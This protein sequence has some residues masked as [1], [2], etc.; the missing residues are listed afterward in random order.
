MRHIPINDLEVPDGWR[1]DAAAAIAAVEAHAGS[2]RKVRNAEIE[3]HAA[4]TWRAMKDA[5]M[6][7]SDDKCWYCEIRQDRSL[8]AV[9]HYRPKGKVD[10]VPTHP[11]YWW[12]A[13]DE[14]NY[15]FTC[16]LCNSATADKKS[17]IVGGKRDQFPLFDESKRATTP[18]SRRDD[19]SPKLLDPIVPLDPTLLTWMVDG[20]PAPRYSVSQNPEW[21]E[22]AAVTIAAYHLNHYR[23]RRRRIRIYNELKMLIQ[24][25]DILYDKAVTNQPFERTSME[26]VTGRIMSI[27]SERAELTATAKQYI[28]E[29]RTGQPNREWLEGVITAA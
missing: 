12:L 23:L 5:L 17:G 14:M 22:R 6:K 16:T 18:T 21:H 19:E 20:N 8:G 25:G 10:G 28:R 26:R 15:R 9:D 3:R 4:K 24:E 11:G 7:L 13:F 1:D 29:Y 2:E 27:L